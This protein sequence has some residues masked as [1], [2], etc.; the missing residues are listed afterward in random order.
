MY[1]APINDLAARP[2]PVRLKRCILGEHQKNKPGE[3]E[4]TTPDK[5][6]GQPPFPNNKPEANSGAMSKPLR[7]PILFSRLVG[8]TGR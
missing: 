1:I 6:S 3:G 2:I 5:P 8:K 4:R 7:S